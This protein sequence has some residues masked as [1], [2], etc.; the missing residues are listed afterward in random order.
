[1]TTERARTWLSGTAAS[2]K[3]SQKPAELARGVQGVKAVE[4]DIH[5]Q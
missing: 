1:M 2:R 3:E 5:V 4:N